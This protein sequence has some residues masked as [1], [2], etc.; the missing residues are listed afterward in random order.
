MPKKTIYQFVGERIQVDDNGCWIWTGGKNEWGYGVCSYN[1]WT[2]KAHRV[3]FELF[4][5]TIPKGFHLDHVKARGCRSTLCVN[6]WHL[7]AVTPKEN[8]R[9]G[10][11]GKWE[12]TKTHCPK[13]HPYEGRN[14]VLDGGKRKCR[15]CLNANYRRRYAQ[16]KAS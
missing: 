13:N 12:L 9:R 8:S 11:A 7:E 6:P 2:K 16:K 4:G 3:V 5:G 10:D 14:L 15:E 1:Y